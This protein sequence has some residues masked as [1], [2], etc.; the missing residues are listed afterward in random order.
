MI[1][2]NSDQK[3]LVQKYFSNTIASILVFTTLF[4]SLTE[5]A[6]GTS[7]RYVFTLMFAYY[8]ASSETIGKFTLSRGSIKYIAFLMLYAFCFFVFGSGN[9]LIIH[10]F[11]IC[12]GV[13]F[14]YNMML[15]LNY[16]VVKIW[17]YATKFWYVIYFTLIVELIIVI[18]GFQ[19]LLYETFPEAN[20]TYGLPAY[21]SL[22][23]T[24]AIFF[25]LEFNGLNSIILQA[26]AYGQLCVMLTILG[27]SYTQSSFRKSHLFKF[28]TLVMCPLI[29]YSISPNIT[30]SIIFIFIIANIFFVKFYLGVFSTAKFIILS[31]VISIVVCLYYLSDLGFVR[32]YNFNSLYTLFMSKQIEFM[33]T[34][35]FF[36][37][38]L[39]VGLDEYYNVAPKF[40]IAY[41]SYLSVS[42]L[43]FGFVNLFVIFKFTGLTFKQVKALNAGD[44]TKKRVVEIQIA[45][46]LFVLSMLLSSVHFPVITSYLGSLIFIFHL[47]FGLYMLKINITIPAE[48]EAGSVMHKSKY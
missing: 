5:S 34:R 17:Q 4:I 26:Q 22:I 19:G 14:V 31:G 13:V 8:I 45:N 40:E 38:V 36:D 28:L 25:R 48:S 21:R 39:G 18:Y 27:F 9:N 12:F 3:P 6:Y 43:I 20:R 29:L 32:T 41:L 11:T 30:A 10:L 44:L 37:Y 35:S 47:S 46:L 15:S 1:N 2:D 24:F 42:G 23:N 16:D 33:V 7:L